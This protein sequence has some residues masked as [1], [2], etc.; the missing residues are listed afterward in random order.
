MFLVSEGQAFARSYPCVM[1][2][3][4]TCLP[5]E[6]VMIQ[7]IRSSVWLTEMGVSTRTVPVSPCIRVQVTGENELSWLSLVIASGSLDE[8]HTSAL[9]VVAMSGR[10]YCQEVVPKV[11]TVSTDELDGNKDCE[12]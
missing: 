6:V 3:N 5:E 10:S 1:Y 11:I 7:S 12:F 9:R 8:T 2:T 4:V